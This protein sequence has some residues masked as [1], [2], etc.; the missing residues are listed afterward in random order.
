M[1]LKELLYDNLGDATPSV[2]DFLIAEPIMEDN[3]FSRSVILIVD[4][5]EEE[6]HVGII[7]NKPTDVML[8]SI[9]P[10]IEMTENIPVFCGGPVGLDRLTLLHTLGYDLGT[11]FEIIPGLFVGGEI[12]KVIEY[13]NSEDYTEEKIR[14]FLGYCG[15]GK[16][17][18]ISEIE[19][20]FWAVSSN[21]NSKNLLK[22]AGNNYWR[23]EVKK[24]GD[25]LRSWL[26]VPPDP[27]YN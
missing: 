3:Y 5:P 7:L 13:L 23:R 25:D 9:F 17:Q 4:E 2:G 11:S 27:S 24:M 21:I 19:R 20:K 14:F 22:G 10:N 12:N 6:E 8:P 1:D 26:T 16:R 15:W 18:L